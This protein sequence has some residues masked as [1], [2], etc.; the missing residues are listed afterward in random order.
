MNW[1]RFGLDVVRAVAWPIVLIIFRPQIIQLLG[2]LNHLSA[3]SVSAAFQ[4]E[5][6]DLRTQVQ[7]AK[8]EDAPTEVEVPPSDAKQVDP[9]TLEAESKLATDGVGFEPSG[10]PPVNTKSNLNRKVYFDEFLGTSMEE[11]DTYMGRIIRSWTEIE[12]KA[13]R[14][15]EAMGMPK[16]NR[17]RITRISVQKVL[18]ELVDRGILSPTWITIA[19]ELQSMRNQFVHKPDLVSVGSADSLLGSMRD[20]SYLLSNIHESQFRKKRQR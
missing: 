16:D 12:D 13:S 17:G 18:E 2:R 14:L 9:Q 5:A 1:A 4:Q 10:K 3:G 11:R 7:V 6:Q 8:L 15:G 19:R 20:L